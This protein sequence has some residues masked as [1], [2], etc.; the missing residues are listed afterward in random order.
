MVWGMLTVHSC[1]IRIAIATIAIILFG[2][3]PTHTY[4]EAESAELSHTSLGD[5]DFI[6]GGDTDM[7]EPSLHEIQSKASISAWQQLRERI[8]IITTENSAM[9]V[10][11]KCLCCDVQ[12]CFRCVKCGPFSFY[13]FEC[14]CQQHRVSNFFH[15]AEKWEVRIRDLLLLFILLCYYVIE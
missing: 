1:N 2:V 13:C 7:T 8:L 6:I 10:G 3:V 5:H 14:F 4:R 11:Q 12:A 9:P 15:V